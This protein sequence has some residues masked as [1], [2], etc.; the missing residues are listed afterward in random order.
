MTATF[1]SAGIYVALSLLVPPYQT[2]LI[3]NV[4]GYN[5]DTDLNNGRAENMLADADVK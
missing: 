1:I 5:A 4:P 3:E 2:I